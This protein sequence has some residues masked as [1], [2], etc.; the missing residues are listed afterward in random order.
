MATTG[1]ADQGYPVTLLVSGRRCLVVGGGRVAE[2][3]VA[4]L[5]A[6]GA[7]V[8]VVAPEISPGIRREGVEVRAR[9]FRPEDVEGAFLVV[10]ATGVAA[11][12]GAVHERCEATGVLVNAADRPEAC[13]VFLPA[14]LRRGPVSVAV[15]T[16]G[17]SPALAGVLRDAIGELVGPR[18]ADVA[19]ALGAARDELHARDGSTEGLPW[20]DLAV[21]LLAEAAAGAGRA[22]LG[23]LVAGW[24][25]RL[26]EAPEH[27]LP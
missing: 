3:K 21:A 1:P 15:S 22:R 8:T 17:R 6:A 16:G 25:A 5:V 26:G 2:R 4:G 10:A 14:V 9:A 20:R 19:D 24:L 13:S 27:P 18:V 23:D 11:V 7:L 12:D